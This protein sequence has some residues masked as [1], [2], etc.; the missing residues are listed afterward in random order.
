MDTITTQPALLAPESVQ[1]A[2]DELANYLSAGLD[3]PVSIVVTRNRSSLIRLRPKPEGGYDLRTHA[4][5]LQAPPETLRALKRF[6]VTHRRADWRAVCGFIRGAPRESRPV[7]NRSLRTA[8]A[9]HDLQTI[10]DTVN[11]SFFPVPCPCRITWG[12]PASRLRGRVRRHIAYG[13]Y[14]REP[15]LIRIHPLLDDPRVPRDFVAFIVFHERLHAELGAENRSGRQ[16]HHTAR[17]RSLERQ[18]PDFDRHQQLAQSLF[19]SLD[20][21]EP[22][23]KWSDVLT[24]F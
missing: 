7:P 8:G 2:P 16:C 10:L 4:C 1:L 9:V 17:F 22:K 12:R 24:F 3:H 14:H 18:F 19:R 11:A 20:K 15:A 6:L 23:R 13:S 21:P 5:L